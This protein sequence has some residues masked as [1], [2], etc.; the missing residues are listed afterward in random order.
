[1]CLDLAISS[2]IFPA[3]DKS[4]KRLITDIPEPDAEYNQAQTQT[5]PHTESETS[6]P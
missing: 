5:K 1:M 6:F 4:P 2:I 3:Q